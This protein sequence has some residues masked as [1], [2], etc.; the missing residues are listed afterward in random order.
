MPSMNCIVAS[1]GICV[2]G[3]K[4]YLIR[5]YFYGVSVNGGGIFGGGNDELLV[6]GFRN[7][8]VAGYRN[9]YFYTSLQCMRMWL[10]SATVPFC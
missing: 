7:I 4:S 5:S 6:V 8:G 9:Q 10:A 1:R 3:G 2:C